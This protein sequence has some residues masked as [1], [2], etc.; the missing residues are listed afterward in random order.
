MSVWDEAWNTDYCT[1]V[2]SVRSGN[3]SKVSGTMATED[4]GVMNLNYSN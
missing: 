1:V 3:G 2:L 4:K